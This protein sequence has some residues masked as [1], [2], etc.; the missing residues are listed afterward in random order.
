M[1]SKAHL[2]NFDE[3]ETFISSSPIKSLPALEP[4]PSGRVKKPA[5]RAV[6]KK[7]GKTSN[8]Q[9]EMMDIE[10]ETK[11]KVKKVI[12]KVEEESKE[13]KEVETIKLIENPRVPADQYILDFLEK[14]EPN[15]RHIGRCVNY[16][17]KSLLPPLSLG[18][19]KDKYSSYLRHRYNWNPRI[20]ANDIENKSALMRD[21]TKQE[22]SRQP[23]FRPTAVVPYPPIRGWPVKTHRLLKLI[24]AVRI[25]EDLYFYCRVRGDCCVYE[26]FFFIDDLIRAEWVTAAD[27]IPHLVKN[28]DFKTIDW[29]AI[30]LLDI[31]H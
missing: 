25:M 5:A 19:E 16:Y 29:N 12:Q 28:P 6:R 11:P 14:L 20:L 24:I 18:C 17:V 1:G 23:S 27:F 21:A 3:D 10:L 30:I 2:C 22:M 13:V 7:K 9:G 31:E 26:T 8:K 4:I 15:V